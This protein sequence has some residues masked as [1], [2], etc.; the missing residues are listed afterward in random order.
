MRAAPVQEGRGGA[1]RKDQGGGA[2]H[3]DALRHMGGG[4]MKQM[5]TSCATAQVRGTGLV[6]FQRRL[7]K[8]RRQWRLC[9]GLCLPLPHVLCA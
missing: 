2:M 8:G 5:C 6:V 4:R 3:N 1:M 9:A 7:T